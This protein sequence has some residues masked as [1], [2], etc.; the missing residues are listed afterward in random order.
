MTRLTGNLA[1]PLKLAVTRCDDVHHLPPYVEPAVPAQVGAL[2]DLSPGVG[3]GWVS[4]A[5]PSH[6]ALIIKVITIAPRVCQC[7]HLVSCS[8]VHPAVVRRALEEHQLPLLHFLLDFPGLHSPPVPLSL[9]ARD[10]VYPV[11][12]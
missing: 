1:A 2:P 7:I 10:P 4:L 5:G 6:H 11:G 12:E 3:R 8:D 9:V